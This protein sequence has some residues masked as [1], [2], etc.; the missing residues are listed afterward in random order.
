MYI[1]GSEPQ[2]GSI[3]FTDTS[4]LQLQKSS[5]VQ[6]NTVT[7]RHLTRAVIDTPSD[8]ELAAVPERYVCSY[9]G[10]SANC[11]PIEPGVYIPFNIQ[12]M[13]LALI[14]PAPGF[15][16]AF[17]GQHLLLMPSG[18]PF[19]LDRLLVRTFGICPL[20]QPCLNC[21]SLPVLF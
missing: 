16:S 5:A 1:E 11:E 21:V 13:V 17:S 20:R 4:I 19:G 2:Q 18:R 7:Q 14:K 6:L 9:F 12:P 8:P 3:G 15:Q 10:V